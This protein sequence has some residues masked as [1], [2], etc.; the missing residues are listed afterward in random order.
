MK[1]N[2]FYLILI[3]LTTNCTKSEVS[4]FGQYESEGI[5][6]FEKPS[7]F[8]NGFYG[9]SVGAGLSLN[10]DYSF[11]YSTCANLMSGTWKASKDSLFL[12]V[13]ENRYRIDSLNQVSDQGKLPKASE[14]PFKFR[15]EG[16]VLVAVTINPKGKK[17]I[18]KLK[19]VDD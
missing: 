16:N 2:L 1:T 12:Y 9:Y 3:F 5:S 6:F 7:F 4:L 10:P 17:L 14:K 15:I 18:S 13:E 11:E 19:K 8:I